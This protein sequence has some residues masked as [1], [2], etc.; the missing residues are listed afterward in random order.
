M[1]K[2]E[3][4]QKSSQKFENSEFWFII[5]SFDSEHINLLVMYC[6]I[7]VLY[8]IRIVI[9]KVP[10][11]TVCKCTCTNCTILSTMSQL[12][13]I[14]LPR[15]TRKIEFFLAKFFIHIVTM[16]NST[17]TRHKGTISF[18]C[19]TGTVSPVAFDHK[20]ISYVSTFL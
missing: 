19:G 18:F 16:Y 14:N 7:Q 11:C 10:F 2:Q 20:I 5:V 13:L 4:T 6:V 1:K 3:E 17:D 8:R 12:L 9:K 15:K